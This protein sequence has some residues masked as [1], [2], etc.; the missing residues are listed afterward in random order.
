MNKKI[1]A[2]AVVLGAVT[3]AGGLVGCGKAEEETPKYTIVFDVNGNGVKDDGEQVIE[4]EKGTTSVDLPACPVDSETGFAGV[5]EDFTLKDENIIVKAKYGDGSQ[6]NPYLVS[7]AEQFAKILGEEKL[8]TTYF[9]LL[10]DIDFSSQQ[11]T[12]LGATQFCSVID[13]DGHSVTGLTPEQFGNTNGCLIGDMDGGS[14]QNLTIVWQNEIGALINKVKSGTNALSQVIVRSAKN[15]EM[16]DSANHKRFI[17]TD[18]NRHGAMLVNS[19]I[20]GTLNIRGCNVT[21]Y[22]DTNDWG[23]DDGFNWFVGS[24]YEQA[25]VDLTGN[26]HIG[27]A[28]TNVSEFSYIVKFGDEEKRTAGDTV[29]APTLLEQNGFAGVWVNANGDV[30]TEFNNKSETLTAKYGDGTQA[31]PYLVATAEQ[32]ARILTNH[33]S[34][35]ATY[36]K[37]LGDIDLASVQVCGDNF[38]GEIDGN[39][40]TLKNVTGT[41]F[42]ATWGAIFD[43]ATDATFKNLNIELGDNIA[44][45]VAC[46]YG[47]VTF[48]NITVNN[49]RGVTTFLTADDN[50]EGPFV[51]IVKS[52]TT[53]FVNCTNNAN[54]MSTAKYFGVFVGGY[55]LKNTSINFTNCVNNGNITSAG[56]VGILIGNPYLGATNIVVDSV[57]VKDKDGFKRNLDLTGVTSSSTGNIVTNASAHFLVAMADFEFSKNDASLL[58]NLNTG[59]ISELTTKCKTLVFGSDVELIPTDSGATLPAGEYELILSAYAQNDRSA[60]GGM[61][62]LTNISIKINVA[63]NQTSK[64]LNNVLYG[65]QD[66]GTYQ[67]RFSKTDE[68]LSG[69]SWTNIEG[70]Q[71]IRYFLDTENGVYVID[72]TDY[73]IANN[74]T[75]GGNENRLKL[76]VNVN[77]VSKLMLAYRDGKVIDFVTDFAQGKVATFDIN[78]NGVADDGDIKVKF[79]VGDTTLSS[80]PALPTS[81]EG[82]DFAPIGW[83]NYTLDDDDI[84]IGLK[85]ATGGDSENAHVIKTSAQFATLLNKYGYV[86]TIEYTKD[87]N[88]STEADA[89][90]KIEHYATVDV[91]STK[92]DDKWGS[93]V[94]TVTNKAYFKVE[95]DIDISSLTGDINAKW[96]AGEIDFNGHSLYAD[97]TKFADNEGAMFLNIYDTTIKNLT[98][99]LDENLMS[100]ANRV[101][102]GTVTLENISIENASNKDYAVI[103]A[104]DNNEGPFVVH[105]LAGTLN[106]TNCVNNANYMS[107]SAYSGILVGGYAV[108]GTKVNF[109]SCGNTGNII[110]SGSI[111]LF[112][113]NDGNTKNGRIA[114]DDYVI[115]NCY[116]TGD[117]STYAESHILITDRHSRFNADN[118]YASLDNADG[119]NPIT[120]LTST[121]TATKDGYNIVVGAD[122]AEINGKQ[123]DLIISAF[124]ENDKSGNGY[125]TLRTNITIS[126]TGS[127]GILVFENVV[128]SIMDKTTYEEYLI[129]QSKTMP[130]DPQWIQI[131][132]YT[133]VKYFVDTENHVYVV[134]YSEYEALYNLQNNPLRVNKAFAS[135]EKTIVVKQSNKVLDFVVNIAEVSSASGLSVGDLIESI[136]T[137]DENK[138]TAYAIG[139]TISEQL[140][141][142]HATQ[143]GEELEM[144][145][146]DNDG[147][148]DYSFVLKNSNYKDNPVTLTYYYNGRLCSGTLNF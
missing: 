65:L 100:L 58:D 85:Y 104:D 84:L 128:N 126:K 7:T 76:D 24:I 11:G 134:D 48:E 17:L 37:L 130:T 75:G 23:V 59:T 103:S 127:N 86:C 80:V 62:L 15:D 6:N 97:G 2:G 8:N 83:E 129:S 28:F 118:E 139:V 140:S 121:H 5:W 116:N 9:K 95:A 13:G 50:N 29:T 55:A 49:V 88:P 91:T 114:K 132:G 147:S 3:M 112:F 101:N 92:T 82:H 63:D 81:V 96:F 144:T 106:M 131:A 18:I 67:A 10:N 54:F 25:T 109:T 26:T 143:N 41:N 27:N 46:T 16:R 42:I 99:V 142:I 108:G 141:Y 66:I 102:G 71:G 72:Y 137:I 87:G 43:S 136:N 120:L 57:V 98:V 36:F 45:L 89:D 4:F 133:G 115:I 79:A 78:G 32:F 124:A 39:G 47:N 30:W 34:G 105:V 70:Y 94:V 14:I 148:I 1:V 123:C 60:T 77:G 22:A 119:Y 12:T 51:Q 125:M 74:L 44:S 68:D 110:S 138:G 73:E 69:V 145:T 90:T 56:S 31:N 21:M 35:T 107:Y 146:T 40:Y 117:I 52:G 19:A 20:A 93:S 122:D 111:G 135:C 53:S 61:S 33:S 38:S 113:G 64:S